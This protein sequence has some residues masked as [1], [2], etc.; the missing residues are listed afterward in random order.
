MIIK[1]A[2]TFYLYPLFGYN[3]AAVGSLIGFVAYFAISASRARST[4][5]FSVRLK[6]WITAAVGG[7]LCGG[8]A[9]LVGMLI[10]PA[11]LALPVQIIVGAGLYGMT[12]QLSGEVRDELQVVAAFIKRR[13]AKK[14]G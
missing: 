2:A 10:R 3:G 6:T 1:T 9:Y 11:V 14:G 13:I 4:L 12:L 8:G 5:L 7:L